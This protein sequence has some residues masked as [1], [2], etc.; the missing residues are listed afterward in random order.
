LDLGNLFAIIIGSIFINNFIFAKFLGICPFM[1]VS[2]K[3]ESSIGMGMAVTF[4][5]TL[6]SAVTWIVYNYLLVPFNLE[7]LQTI[8]FILIIASLVQFVEMVVRK[9]SPNLYKA[10]GVFL[11]LITTNCAV[12]GVAILNVQEKYNF[13]E[14]TVNGFA[15]AVGFTMALI[16]LAGVR[17]RLEYA[18][19]PKAFQGVAIAFISAGLL[20]MAFMG[21]SGMKI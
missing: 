1:G 19:V 3:I 15:A 6:A 5:M 7:Y 8:S 17:E 2:K 13:I 4:V 18:E 11:P 10:L 14:T 21:F 20:A 16:L 9:T 12:L